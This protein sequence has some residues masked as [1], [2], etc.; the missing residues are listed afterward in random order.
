MIVSLCGQPATDLRPTIDPNAIA[1]LKFADCIP[2]AL[3][4][5]MLHDRARD[6]HGL[7]ALLA[8]PVRAV[9]NPATNGP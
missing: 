9:V 3:A 6:A 7:A 8:E 4:E 5:R 2:T 1:A